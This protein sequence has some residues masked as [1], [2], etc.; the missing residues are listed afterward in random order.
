LGKELK[1]REDSDHSTLQLDNVSKEEADG[2]PSEE[3]IVSV[4]REMLMSERLAAT[5]S[6]VNDEDSELSFRSFK[7]SFGTT[8][9]SF[10]LDD[11][12]TYRHQITKNSFI[13]FTIEIYTTLA[14]I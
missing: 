12:K 7:L 4:S 2:I 3:R 13:N 11:Y 10:I 9:C 14:T 1:L 5:A 6:P 8:S